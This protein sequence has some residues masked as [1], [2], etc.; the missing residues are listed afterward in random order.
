MLEH[1]SP[2]QQQSIAGQL[3]QKFPSHAPAWALHAGFLE[4]AS[5]RLAALERGLAA[6]PD[7]DTRG[8][9]LVH[10]ALAL[11]RLG[12][13][14]RALTILEPLTT[15][16]GNSISTQAKAYHAAAVIRSQTHP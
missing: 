9:L 7:P 15:S 6:R 14:Q 5:E 12:E 3:V 8:S 2:E 11:H 1:M 10:R 16:G 4:D 13:T